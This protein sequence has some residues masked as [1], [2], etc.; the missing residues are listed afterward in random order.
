MRGGKESWH[1]L[2][3]KRLK[4]LGVKPLYMANRIN[5]TVSGMR[6]WF[7]PKTLNKVRGDK[8]ACVLEEIAND[9]NK[10]ADDIRSNTRDVE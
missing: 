4:D 1:E 2:A 3:Y 9:V 10:M 7:K 8:I 6:R 5:V